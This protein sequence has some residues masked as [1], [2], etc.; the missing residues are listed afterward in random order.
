MLS[1]SAEA[2]LL[3]FD[4]REQHME[5]IANGEMA[6]IWD[7][8]E[9][10]EWV[11]NADRYDATDRWIN[12]RFESATTIEPSDRVLDV[13]CGTGKSTRDAAR[14]AKDGLVLGVDLSS[15]MLEEARRRSAEEGL[16]NVEHL[17]AD[18][19]VHPFEPGAFDVAIS[20]FGAMFFAD[21]TAAFA[22]IR[23]GLRPGGTIAVLAWQRFED[24]EWLTTIFDALMAG[25][26]L[27][28]PSP[29]QPGPFGLAD[30]QQVLALLDD[31]GYVDS[32]MASITA[33]MWLGDS[34]E[35]AWA[36]V[37]EMGIVRGL[38]GGLD[39]ETAASALGRLRRRIEMRRTPE[40]VTLGSAAWLITARQP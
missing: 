26:D 33:P 31:A 37:S 22:N 36:F 1:A 25:R 5:S 28:A 21:P 18:A 20:V 10:D 13:G 24:N 34:P 30:P 6:A 27:P 8:E 39:D 32:R 40:G 35:E 16:A 19:Q 4:E 9:G 17:R 7:G 38:T 3:L 2:T 29:G 12:E 15:K 23:R 14:R 11:A